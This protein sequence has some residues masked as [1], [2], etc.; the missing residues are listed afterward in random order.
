MIR[1]QARASCVFCRIVDG[2]DNAAIVADWPDA[3]AFVPLNPVTEGHVLV[4][5]RRHVIDALESPSTT[6]L[7]MR[8]AAEIAMRPCNLITSAGREATQT[9]MHF[10][11]HI[12]PRAAEDGL[13]LP[14]TGQLRGEP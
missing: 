3:I 5:P 10:H 12:V 7:V 11:V 13:A 2:L 6:C 8:H 14:W 4:V 9:V 1:A